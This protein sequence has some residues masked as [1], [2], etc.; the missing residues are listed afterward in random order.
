MLFG[1]LAIALPYTTKF[2]IS[3]L[4]GIIVLASGIILLF[5]ALFGKNRQHLWLDLVMGLLRI[6][7]G[8][9]VLG[10]L[11]NAVLFLTI[12]LS[13]LLVAEGIFAIGLAFKL[14][15]RNPA[16]GW[17]LLKGC[18]LGSMLSFWVVLF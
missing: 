11:F 5:A 15:G 10:N 16:W 4:L 14:L 8:V 1:G 12:F 7:V 9:V 17:V 6:F 3:Q 2:G 18:F 13:A